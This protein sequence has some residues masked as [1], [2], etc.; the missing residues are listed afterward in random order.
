MEQTHNLAAVSELP[1]AQE[2]VEH[3]STNACRLCT[4]IATLTAGARPPPSPPDTAPPP[5][6]QVSPNCPDRFDGCRGII[7]RGKLH[8]GFLPR[9]PALEAAEQGGLVGTP[10]QGQS[11]FG[12][13]HACS[14]CKA[15]LS[16]EELPRSLEAQCNTCS[17]GATKPSSP[18]G[19]GNGLAHPLPKE[20]GQSEQSPVPP[21]R[22][23]PLPGTGVQACSSHCERCCNSMSFPSHTTAPQGRTRP[24]GG[25]H[26]SSRARLRLEN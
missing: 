23:A 16:K 3:N 25:S 6:S 13:V 1:A 8:D 4:A 26:S 18:R 19:M 22:T 17:S 24:H 21:G 2:A 20:Q 10:L 12:A 14:Q 9:T 5:A 7:K 11:A 15:S